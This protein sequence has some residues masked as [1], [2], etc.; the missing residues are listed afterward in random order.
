MFTGASTSDNSPLG[1]LHSH[2]IRTTT[3]EFA[4]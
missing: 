4:P 1:S 3:Q 2:I